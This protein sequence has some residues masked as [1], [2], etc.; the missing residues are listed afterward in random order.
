MGRG[1]D[2][3]RT[4][5][6]IGRILHHGESVLE[7]RP[8]R[9][10]VRLRGQPA[11]IGE[12]YRRAKGPRRGD[13][14]LAEEQPVVRVG[15]VV[16][17]RVRL[18]RRGRAGERLE[19]FPEGDLPAFGARVRRPSVRTARIRS[20]ARGDA[21]VAA[22]GTAEQPGGAEHGDEEGAK[23]HGF[24][25]AASMRI[26]GWRSIAL[27]RCDGVW[28]DPRP[29]S[30]KHQPS[31]EEVLQ[32]ISLEERKPPPPPPPKKSAQPTFEEILASTKPASEQP[33][34]GPPERRSRP[35][36]QK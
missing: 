33:P 20:T 36:R 12:R 8:G 9:P 26:A 30:E 16:G 7:Y 5:R 27:Q 35:P 6:R 10:R 17:H 23:H 3:E 21:T 11:G 22:R 31:F 28:Y 14:L 29:V 13:P 1:A 25:A 4:V 15:T 18:P 24:N 19:V 2:A 32:G 34:P